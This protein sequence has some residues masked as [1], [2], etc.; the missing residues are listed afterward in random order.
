MNYIYIEDS[1]VASLALDLVEKAKSMLL[2]PR[3][4][5]EKMFV[6][7]IGESGL[8][9]AAAFLSAAQAAPEL[10]SIKLLFRALDKKDGGQNKFIWTTSAG[11]EVES[12][13][14][15]KVTELDALKK[16]AIVLVDGVVRTGGT[17]L[18]VHKA[19]IAKVS[20][21]PVKAV[22]DCV[23]VWSY[24]IAVNPNSSI[25]PTWFG[26]LYAPNNYVVL[27]RDQGTPNVSVLE[28]TQKVDAANGEA[29]I[30][31]PV[32][33]PPVVLRA[34][35][36]ADCE[37]HVKSPASMNR[38]KS[39]D[40]YFDHQTKSRRVFIIEV[41]NQA[42]GYVSFHIKR[43][44]LWLD[45]IL[46]GDKERENLKEQNVSAGAALMRFVASYA[47][48]VGCTKIGAWAITENMKFYT[49]RGFQ[50]ATGDNIVFNEAGGRE[51]YALIVMQLS[52]GRQQT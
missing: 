38:Y 16:T 2:S 24:A 23:Y 14:F 20:P 42:V 39:V 3:L 50:P 51:E 7:G 15:D 35:E 33:Y 13:D 29:R 25:I 44:T 37:F 49:D 41:F 18:A 22:S 8:K 45:Y 11:E 31:K 19:M 32:M 1:R 28:V 10:N 34:P 4:S 30:S 43:N 52:N 9:I 17:L 46:I 5:P 27:T 6:V 47:Q 26:T 48:S 36:S 40:R 21:E 12:I